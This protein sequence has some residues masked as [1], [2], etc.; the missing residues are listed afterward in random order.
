MYLSNDTCCVQG[1]LKAA[2]ALGK[3]YMEHGGWL[4]A[5]DARL[6]EEHVAAQVEAEMGASQPYDDVESNEEDAP[7][8][9]ELQEEELEQPH[10]RTD[11]S[12]EVPSDDWLFADEASATGREGGAEG[13]G[14][15]VSTASRDD[16]AT[17][18]RSDSGGGDDDWLLGEGDPL[19]SINSLQHGGGR[20][21][22]PAAVRHPLHQESHETYHDHRKELVIVWSD[23][24]Q[25][26]VPLYLSCEHALYYLEIAAQAGNWN[27]A[28]RKGLDRFLEG[29]PS[30]ALPLYEV[31]A[32]VGYVEAQANVAYL[33]T[34]AADSEHGFESVPGQ[35]PSLQSAASP[36]ALAPPV[37]GEDKQPHDEPSF[38]QRAASLVRTYVPAL[39][40]MG[41][42]GW[43]CACAFPYLYVVRPADGVTNGMQTQRSLSG[44]GRH[45]PPMSQPLAEQY[46]A[47]ALHRL[48][49]ASAQGSEAATLRAGT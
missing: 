35:Q 19:W 41:A 26:V 36:A 46:R 12:E 20:P 47:A 15:I 43:L 22:F 39:N 21:V 28:L 2:L 40:G 9:D 5:Y 44:G 34:S 49:Q 45:A 14:R 1:H 4:D 8:S 3:A 32:E 30:E 23:G 10:P 27:S 13:G 31:A 42:R 24:E 48:K 16:E 37:G 11:H 38:M 17:A 33:Y 7:G 25:R 18:A 29:S 6:F